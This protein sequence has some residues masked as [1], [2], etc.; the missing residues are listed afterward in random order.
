MPL[1]TETC[2]GISADVEV[3]V[4]TPTITL[5]AGDDGDA[6]KREANASGPYGGCGG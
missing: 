2:P 6:A 5:G 3:T 1:T 4:T